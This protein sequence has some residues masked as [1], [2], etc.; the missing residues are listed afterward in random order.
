MD[1]LT[2]SGLFDQLVPII[3]LAV[4]AAAGY[5]LKAVR[6]LIAKSENKL[7]DAIWNKLVAEFTAVGAITPDQLASLKAMP[8]SDG[9]PKQ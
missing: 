8:P 9:K 2:D 6:N 7:D 1:F 4:G 5:G 3:V